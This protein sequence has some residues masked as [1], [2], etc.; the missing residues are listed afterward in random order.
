MAVL[1]PALGAGRAAALSAG[2]VV[3][4]TVEGDIHDIG[5]NL[6][7]ALLSAN[8]FAV[9]DLGAD[10]KVERFISAAEESGATII[11]L[12]ALLTTTMLG[13]RRLVEELR[14]RGLRDKYKVLVGGAPVTRRW[15][16]EIGADGYGENALAAVRA[17]KALAGRA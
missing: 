14:Q 7:S 6:V 8:G 16:D 17:A 10:V 5:K 15:A 4:G 13:Q 9:V 12:S 3:I 2:R 1:H 11:G